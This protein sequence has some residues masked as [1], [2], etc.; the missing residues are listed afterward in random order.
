MTWTWNWWCGISLAKDYIWL[1]L[2]MPVWAHEAKKEI[3]PV[4][5]KIKLMT[6]KQTIEI[7]LFKNHLILGKL[8]YYYHIFVIIRFVLHKRLSLKVVLLFTNFAFNN[9]V[10]VLS[11]LNL[12]YLNLISKYLSPIIFVQ[13]YFSF[14]STKTYI[15]KLSRTSIETI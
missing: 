1:Q 9:F 2:L 15:I 13:F 3:W 4:F 12:P 10:F 14:D 5:Y 8:R 11:C 6:S 7:T